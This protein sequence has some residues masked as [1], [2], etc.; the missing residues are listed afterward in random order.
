MLI[1]HVVE[2][3]VLN[4]RVHRDLDITN[5]AAAALQIQAL[6]H[7]LRP[8]RLT[9]ELPVANPSAAS[10]SAVARTHRMCQSVGIPCDVTGPGAAVTGSL[11]AA[12][13]RRLEFGARGHR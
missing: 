5:R 8:S 1:S 11:P 3:G 2:D 4:V 9:V 13:P 6:V 10:L 7:A 12:A